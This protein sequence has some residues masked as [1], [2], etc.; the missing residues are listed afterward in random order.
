[1]RGYRSLAY[2][3]SPTGMKLNLDRSSLLTKTDEL[4]FGTVRIRVPRFILKIHTRHRSVTKSEP[5]P[6]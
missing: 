4:F 5:E 2:R 1:M 3:K 6:K